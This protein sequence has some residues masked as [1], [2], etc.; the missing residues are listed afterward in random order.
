[1]RLSIGSKEQQEG[2]AF[3]L[4]GLAKGDCWYS[5]MEGSNLLW[6]GDEN[7]LVCGIYW[8]CGQRGRKGC[9]WWS[10]AV[11][12][13]I[14]SGERVREKACGQP[15][16]FSGYL[17]F[18]ETNLNLIWRGWWK[19]VQ[20]YEGIKLEHWKTITFI[21]HSSPYWFV[22]F[23]FGFLVSFLNLNHPCHGIM[24][25][26]WIFAWWFMIQNVHS[27]LCLQS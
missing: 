10:I 3:I 12:A 16:W 15:T 17:T 20:V 14:G 13:R 4:V 5:E 9:S 7:V 22:Q 24:A 21:L 26:T 18:W 8:R 2:S 11:L 6:G 19:F 25:F 1:M 23:R 27:Y